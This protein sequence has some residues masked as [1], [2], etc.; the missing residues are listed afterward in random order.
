MKFSRLIPGKIST[1]EFSDLLIYVM[2]CMH[3]K[4]LDCAQGIS[5]IVDMTDTSMKHFSIPYMSKFFSLVQGRLHP[6]HVESALFLNAPSW[7]GTVWSILKQMMSSEFLNSSVH[8]I[9]FHELVAKHLE[10]GW[11]PLMTN[12]IFIGNRNARE[13]VNGFIVRRKEIE[14]S[15]LYDDKK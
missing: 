12:D 4:E 13:I 15:R 6:I 10:P 1:S 8:R 14:T 9:T 7:F 3:E 2:N 11:E 5:L